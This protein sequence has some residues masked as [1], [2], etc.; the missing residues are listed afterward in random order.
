MAREAEAVLEQLI[1]LP[2]PSRN[3][4]ERADWIE[5]YL[6]G[7][8]A[9]P[10]RE[11]NNVWCIG[12][13][14]AAGCP[15]LLLNAH[16]DTV[17]PAAGWQR[18]PFCPL[19]EGDRLY[20]LGSNDCGGGLCS[21]MQVFLALRTA[22]LPYR[23]VFLASAEEEV[24]GKNGLERALPLLPPVDLAIVGE[25]TGMR[26]AIA[27]KGLMVLDCT[28]RGKAGGGECHLRGSGGHRLVPPLCLR[29]G[30]GLARPGED[31]GHDD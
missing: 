14:Q 19:W 16:I 12:R 11:G 8:G 6:R 5:L 15:T 28:A 13:E 24:S 22:P 18:D 2:A 25:P 27:E 29:E 1:A 10:H 3:E 7:R 23:L 30:F 17:K 26:P 21:L 9:E 4:G 31:V 20:G